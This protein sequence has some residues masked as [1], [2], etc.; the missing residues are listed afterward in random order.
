MKEE[1]SATSRWRKELYIIIFEADTFR[2]KFFDVLLIGM[3]LLSVLLVCLD[4]VESIEQRFFHY[5]YILEWIFTI[6]FTVEYILRLLCVRKKR[7]YIFSFFG[8]IDLLALLPTYL[9]IF[10]TGVHSLAVI[11]SIR[12]LRIFRLL[13]LSR[14][15]GEAEILLKALKQS[16]YKITVF[17][18]AVLTVVT[19]MGAVMYLV[20]GKENGFTSIPKS[21]YWAIVTMTTVGYG[22]ITPMT[23]LGKTLASIL[24][25]LG[26]G[27]IAVPTGIVTSELN[28]ARKDQLCKKCGQSLK[29]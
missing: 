9:G 18:L 11:R 5:F 14:Y 12:I 25:I 15:V 4:S 28:N 26:Y 21:M 17:I 29:K 2:G 7:R 19:F 1:N 22:D 6:F 16:M 13:K 23:S 27:I 20:E 24:M 10:F 8:M 3:I